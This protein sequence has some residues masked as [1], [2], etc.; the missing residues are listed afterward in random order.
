MQSNTLFFAGA[1]LSSGQKP[2]TFAALDDDS[3]ITILE[4]WDIPAALSFLR[5]HKNVSLVINKPSSK[6]AQKAY[7]DFKNQLVQTGFQSFSQ[8]DHTKHWFETNAQDCYHAWLGQNPLPRRTLEGRLQRSLILYEQALRIED[9]M[10]IF[11]EI[12]RFKLIKGVFRLENV[13][14]SKELDALAAA[15]LAWMSINRPEQIVA[16]GELV[17]PTPG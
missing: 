14:S 1:D 13:Y 8:K 10:D 11:E 16:T 5:D 6:I 2:V 3:N 12:T 4:K 17:L 9:P 7:V 15:Y